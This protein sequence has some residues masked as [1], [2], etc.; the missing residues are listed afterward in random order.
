VGCI[1]EKSTRTCN[2]AISWK[3]SHDLEQEQL[4]LEISTR[5]AWG[6][7]IVIQAPSMDLSV[8]CCLWQSAQVALRYE[9]TRELCDLSRNHL[10]ACQGLQEV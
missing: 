1:G 6:M 3:V 10:H 8:L 2:P 9:R 5:S 4:R 7:H